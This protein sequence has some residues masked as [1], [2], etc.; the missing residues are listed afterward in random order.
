MS[1]WSK[2]P[3]RPRRPKSSPRGLTVTFDFRSLALDKYSKAVNDLYTFLTK[4]RKA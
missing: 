1:K 4:G 2:H 3:P